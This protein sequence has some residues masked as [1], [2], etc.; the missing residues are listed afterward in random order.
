VSISCD[1]DCFDG[2]EHCTAVTE[3]QSVNQF[4]FMFG[5]NHCMNR[6]PLQFVGPRLQS[7]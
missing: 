5:D 1:S 6:E 7:H 3:T 4:I 2:Q